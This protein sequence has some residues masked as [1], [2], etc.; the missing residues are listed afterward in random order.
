MLGR[1]TNLATGMQMQRQGAALRLH[2]ER[3]GM[4]LST[5]RTADL[6]RATG[7]D[8]SRAI[9]L[10]R[11]ILMIEAQARNLALAEGRAG[12]TGDTLALLQLSGETLGPRF[13]AS[14][15]RE[16]MSSVRIGANEGKN[17]FENAISALNV[18]YAGRSIFAGNAVDQAATVSASQILDDLGTLVAG[19]T[20]AADVIALVD[21]YFTGASGGFMTGGY[22]GASAG[23]ADVELAE[24]NAV[25]IQM[26]ADNPSIRNLLRDLALAAMVANRVLS[27]DPAEQRTIMR[28]AGTGLIA[29][30]ND[31]LDMRANLGHVE[32]RINEAQ[33]GQA[34]EKLALEMARNSL[35]AA[36]PYQAAADFQGL[37]AQLQAHYTVVARLSQFSLASFLR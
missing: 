36:D 4:E 11:A 26:R 24:G 28:I 21:D 32:Q 18:R 10:D 19:A 13:L 37:Q 17:H 33:S 30:Q 6:N 23:V 25:A 7:G 5:G 29:S 31:V 34:T 1:V 20:R 22:S 3:V 12:A 16:D 8:V 35:T 15:E 14:A 2:F 9:S 27:T